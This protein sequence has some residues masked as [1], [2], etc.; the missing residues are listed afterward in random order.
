MADII[1]WGAT[2]QARVLR[3][4]L[5][6]TE[7][8]LIALFDNRETS[9][10]FADIPIF[11]GE[12][13]FVDWL[14]AY[15]RGKSNPELRACVAIGGGRGD[16]RLKMQDWLSVQ[17]IPPI[18]LA[19]R[20]AFVASDAIIGDG[21]QILAQAAVCA[22]S[23][24]GKAVIVNTSAS[25]DHCNSIGDGTHIGPGVHLAGEVTVGRNVF[26]GTGATILPRVR[27][28]DGAIV[29]AGAV[30]TK[31]V[32]KSHMVIGNPARFIKPV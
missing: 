31:D 12:S 6:G 5:E 4:L 2:G 20:T 23:R 3:E 11:F 15:S 14:R 17:G 24:L 7:H 30:V 28:G 18:T 22:N 27:I 25:V 1:F 9:S 32:A 8:R 10:P 16:E 26:I 13:G 19:H 29:G 21:S